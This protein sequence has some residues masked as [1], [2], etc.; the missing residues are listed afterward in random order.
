M[1]LIERAVKTIGVEKLMEQLTPEQMRAL[2]YHW[3]AWARPEQILPDD[4][5]TIVLLA[6]R[7]FGKTRT[8]A[9]WVRR[10][11]EDGIARNLMLIAPTHNDLV[12]DMLYGPSGII[13]V[14]PP[15]N[16]PRFRTSD[17]T[18][19]WENGARAVCLTAEEPERTRGKE[20]D[21]VWCDEVAAWR[22]PEVWD[23]LQFCA[24][25]Q[26]MRRVATTTPKPTTLVR[27]LE[28]TADLVIRGS[29][30][31]NR[32]NLSAE[33]L[34]ELKKKYDGTRL[35]RQEL[36]AEVLEDVQ[37]ALWGYALLEGLRALK[38][39]QMCR[40]VVAIDPAVTHG[41]NAD[42]TGIIVAGTDEDG[43]GYVLADKTCKLPANE[44]AK[45]AVRL[46]HEYK[47]DRIVAEKNQGGDLVELTLRT[48]DPNIAYRGVHAKRG[49]YV[50]AEPIAALYEQG[51][52]A[53]VG[54]FSS[55]EDQMCRYVPDDF[56]GSPDRVDALVWALTDLMLDWQPAKYSDSG[57]APNRR[58]ITNGT[59]DEWD[60][61]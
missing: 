7:R 21:T 57:D 43:R 16:R 8:A 51:R 18:L 40:V 29:T 22:Y 12:T 47:A 59:I 46:Y 56:D 5:G 1:T 53:H 35:G 48:I 15:W 44:W 45:L 55:L 41:E 60:D 54:V 20:V 50:R 13:T 9:E 10:R 27:M 14:S 25:S 19:N 30:F 39:P 23:L 24:G 17:N 4:K 58:M 42:E 52:V 3:P 11:V 37:G 32:A 2:Q 26:P 28:K 33:Q 38:P 61:E 31:D 49:K 6:G 36:Y 34:R